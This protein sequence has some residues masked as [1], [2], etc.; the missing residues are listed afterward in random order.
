MNSGF[1]DGDVQ[2]AEL[3]EAMVSSFDFDVGD[4]VTYRCVVVW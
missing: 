3:E 1:V 4:P 2:F